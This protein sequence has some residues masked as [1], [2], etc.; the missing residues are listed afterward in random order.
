LNAS[1]DQDI[2]D[3]FDICLSNFGRSVTYRPSSGTPDL[4]IEIV[5][6]LANFAGKL[7][8]LEPGWEASSADRKIFNTD[9]WR[10]LKKKRYH[11]GKHWILFIENS[12]RAK[13]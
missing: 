9:E 2:V 7:S 1:L 12:M 6:D 11:I 13:R 8:E 3:T 10:V 5:L 4:E